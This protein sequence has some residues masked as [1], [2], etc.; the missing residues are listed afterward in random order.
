MLEFSAFT[1]N[2]YV[3]IGFKSITHLKGCVPSNLRC[4][5]IAIPLDR[6]LRPD[7]VESEH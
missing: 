4:E 2:K 1:L 5:M 7:K 3:V 6:V